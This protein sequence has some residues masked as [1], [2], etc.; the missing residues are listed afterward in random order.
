LQEVA[1]NVVTVTDDVVIIKHL[2]TERRLY[3]LDL[4]IKEMSWRRQRRP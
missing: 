1:A 3:P 4:Y 2:Y